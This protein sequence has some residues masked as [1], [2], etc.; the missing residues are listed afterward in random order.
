MR[1]TPALEEET[2]KAKKKLSKG[3]KLEAQKPLRDMNTIPGTKNIDAGS[4]K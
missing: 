3:K 1:R 4:A 2:M